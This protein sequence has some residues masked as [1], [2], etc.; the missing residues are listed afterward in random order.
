VLRWI[1]LGLTGALVLAGVVAAVG[2][3]LVPRPALRDVSAHPARFAEQ[4]VTW[5]QGSVV[6]YGAE[7]LDVGEGSVRS[8]APTPYGWFLEVGDDTRPYAPVHEAFF[9]GRSLRRLPGDP[10]TVRVSPDGRFAGWVDRRGPRGPFGRIA[11]V[12]VVDVRTGTSLLRTSRGMGSLLDVNI[13]DSYAETPPTFAGFDDR[14]AWWTDADGAAWRWDVLGGSRPERV[15]GVGNA[16]VGRGGRQVGTLVILAGG[17]PRPGVTGGRPGQLSPDRRFLAATGSTG[18]LP[19]T[20]PRT[21]RRLPL[22][23]GGR[24]ADFGGWRPGGLFALVR[25]V[26]PAQ[27]DPTS[28]RSTGRIVDCALPVGRCRTVARVL[29]TPTLV[30][31]ASVDPY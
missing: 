3:W 4:R 8:M 1:A 25:Q 6:H 29:H 11:Q 7:V 30:M 26:P 22:H 27:F 18:R 24:S 16:A 15:R 14:H 9:D 17:R 28:D 19:V 10:D 13:S 31:P 23:H 2:G 5:A 21:G 20:D 12:V